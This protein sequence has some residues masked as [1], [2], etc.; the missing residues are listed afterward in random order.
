MAIDRDLA[1][2]VENGIIL[3]YGTVHLSSGTAVPTHTGVEG[4]RYY[5]TNGEVYKYI[6]ST[7]VMLDASTTV[8]DNSTNGFVAVNVQDAIEEVSEQVDVSASPGFTWGASGNVS[9]SWLVNDTV[10]SNKA[11]R[12]VPVDGEVTDIF[13]ACELS[14]SGTIT[15][16]KRV[17]S[18]F[19]VLATLNVSSVRKLHTTVSGAS[20]SI[21]D[22]LAMK[23]TSGSFKNPVVG[24]VIKGSSS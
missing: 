19:N 10:P 16:Y 12:I 1:Y 2:E 20:V 11:G 18:T 9:N 14:T 24:I 4:D 17:G 8:F 23:V 3:D 22:E 7:W 6:G 21:G 13:F 15:L 5:R